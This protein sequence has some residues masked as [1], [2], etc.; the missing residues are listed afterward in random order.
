MTWDSFP[1]QV[2][3]RSWY[4]LKYFSQMNPRFKSQLKR[5]WIDWDW[6][7]VLFHGSWGACI[8]PYVS[9]SMCVRMQEAQQCHLRQGIVK[10][11]I[12]N[13]STLFPVNICKCKIRH[14]RYT[15]THVEPREWNTHLRYHKIPSFQAGLMELSSYVILARQLNPVI[16]SDHS[17]LES[18]RSHAEIGNCQSSKVPS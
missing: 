16:S 13:E 8:K 9:P 10:C 11:W 6:D 15:C 7:G 18:H 14:H 5:D 2:C 12:C 17:G 4:W 1:H 3:Q